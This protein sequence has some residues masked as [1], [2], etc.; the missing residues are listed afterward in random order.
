MWEGHNNAGIGYIKADQV[1][2]QH[3]ECEPTLQIGYHC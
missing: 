2:F 1:F 3:I